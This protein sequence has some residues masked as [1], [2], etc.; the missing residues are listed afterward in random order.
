MPQMGL[1]IQSGKSTNKWRTPKV[2]GQFNFNDGT[3]SFTASNSVIDLYSVSLDSKGLRVDA[4]SSNGYAYKEFTVLAN[5]EYRWSLRLATAELSSGN[6]SYAW[7]TSADGKNNV[8]QTTQNVPG[9]TSSGTFTT[10]G[11]QTSC[12][13]T[14]K[15]QN[16][17]K[18]A[19][20]DDILLET[21]D[22]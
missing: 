1:G 7:G 4:S 16:S 15:V 9:V 17:G 22:G 21:V 18:Y 12:F 20:W 8:N 6:K 19:V 13:L 5:T 3:H 2:A 10:G 11:S 14:L